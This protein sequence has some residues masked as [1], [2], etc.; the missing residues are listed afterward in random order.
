MC[1]CCRSEEGLYHQAYSSKGRHAPRMPLQ[2]CAAPAVIPP[3]D[4]LTTLWASQLKAILHNMH[5]LGDVAEPKII[6]M[7][8]FRHGS[9][10]NF[11]G[12]G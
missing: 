6:S 5:R 2:H 10:A 11:D 1:I 8:D 9:D 3:V 7:C 4:H 12:V